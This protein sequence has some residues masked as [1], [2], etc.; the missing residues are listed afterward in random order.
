M[1]DKKD[2][3]VIV[4][5]GNPGSKFTYNRHNIG[6]LVVDALADKYGGQWKSSELLA[7]CSVTIEEKKIYLIKPQTFMNSSGKIASWLNKKGIKA[8]NILV[9]HDDLQRP[10]GK[11]S[12]KAG[13]S[14]QGHNG[15][16]S[17]MEQ[18]GPDFYRIRCGI[19]RPEKKSEVADYVLSNFTEGEHNVEKMVQRAIQEINILI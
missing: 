2:I 4:G 17:L 16:K 5:L 15:V 3:K 18:F 10:F 12:I 1:E 6:F 8:E 11:I 7:Y 13:G 9:V 19:D 14:A